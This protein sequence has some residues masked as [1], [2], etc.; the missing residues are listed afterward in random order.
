MCLFPSRFF[1]LLMHAVFW[2]NGRLS[3]LS[4]IS[5]YNSQLLCDYVFF[6]YNS[7]SLYGK[8]LK[9]ENRKSDRLGMIL[10]VSM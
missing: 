2:N 3:S 6:L 1:T 9:K 4:L 5:L 7:L 8:E 10:G